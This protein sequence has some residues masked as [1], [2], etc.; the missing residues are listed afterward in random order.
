MFFQLDLTAESFIP[1]VVLGSI[2][3]SNRESKW[4]FGSAP[5]GHYG[6]LSGPRIALFG[7]LAKAHLGHYWS[8]A[9]VL[10]MAYAALLL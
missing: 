5:L 4:C 3:A 1:R 2:L 10:F 7:A 9:L 8:C 6:A